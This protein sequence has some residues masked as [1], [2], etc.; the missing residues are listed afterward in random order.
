MVR[1]RQPK[2]PDKS[3]MKT[4]G[5]A[6]SPDG[7]RT[8]SCIPGRMT[9]VNDAIAGGLDVF[10]RIGKRQNDLL[11]INAFGGNVTV[12]RVT[13]PSVLVAGRRRRSDRSVVAGEINNDTIILILVFGRCCYCCCCFYTNYDQTNDV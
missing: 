4:D 13:S 9:F 1:D 3:E 12:G 10:Q 11:T 6:L 5:I 8:L 2:R 7:E